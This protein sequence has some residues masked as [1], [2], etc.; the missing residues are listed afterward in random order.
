LFPSLAPG[1]YYVRFQPPPTYAVTTPDAGGDDALD[2]D[3]DTVTACS[4]LVTLVADESNLTVDAGLLPPVPAALG[5]YVWFDRNA[6]GQQNESPFFGANGVTVRLYADDGDGIPEPGADDGSPLRTTAT[7]DDIYGRP[8]YYLFDLLTPGI[9]Y[10]VEFVLPAAA[11]GF[12]T[13]DAGGDDGIDSDADTGTGLGPVVTLGPGEARLD[14]DAGLIA[15]V[16][17]L[18]LGDQVWCD[19]DDDGIFEPE[20]GELGVDGVELDLYLDRNGDGEP[21]LDEHIASTLTF[22]SGGFAGRYRF[23][24][25]DAGDYLVVV[26]LESFSGGGAL[27]GKVSSTGNDPAPDPD[28]DQNGDDNGTD[29]GAVIATRP[30]TLVPG[31]EP[32]P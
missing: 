13:Q 27:S 17:N 5:D 7:A 22:T 10:F 9:P 24:T 4:P 16:G 28:A 11:T 25:L 2:S 23:D 21:T 31:G 29:I 30:V 12:T 15:P 32:P 18:A 26:A 8:G 3:V 6:D 1:S 20:A 19:D 14:L